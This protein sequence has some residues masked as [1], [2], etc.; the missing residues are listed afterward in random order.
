MPVHRPQPTNEMVERFVARYR[1]YP[2]DRSEEGGERVMLYIGEQSY[3]P[4]RFERL[5]E[6]LETK[7]II[8][9]GIDTRVV[10]LK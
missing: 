2:S 1:G 6:R 8:E 10:T 7:T 3:G 9:F 5:P 4:Y